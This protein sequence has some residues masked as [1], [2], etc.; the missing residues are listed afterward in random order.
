MQVKGYQC[1]QICKINA[2]ALLHG[3]SAIIQSCSEII[4]ERVPLSLA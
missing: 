1:F 2:T 3:N 4:L